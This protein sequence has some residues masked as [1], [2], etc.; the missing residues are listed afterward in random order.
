HTHANGIDAMREIAGGVERDIRGR[1]AKLSPAFFA[2]NDFSAH[3]PGVAEKLRRLVDLTL[4]EQFADRARRDRFAPQQKR[5]H[6][7]DLEAA[8]LTLLA[9][10]FGV[11]LAAAAE[12]EIVAHH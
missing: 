5:L 8:L 3:E 1:I 6:K 7:L 9:Q 11:T 2:V 10:E 12:L 4:G